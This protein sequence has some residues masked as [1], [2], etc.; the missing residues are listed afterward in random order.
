MQEVRNVMH[1]IRDAVAGT[2]TGSDVRIVLKELHGRV[3]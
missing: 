2:K 3:S 1:E